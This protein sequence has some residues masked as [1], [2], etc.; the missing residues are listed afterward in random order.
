MILFD[1]QCAIPVFEGLLDHPHDGILQTLLFELA[2]WHA[3]AKLR[4]HTEST[5]K[6]L[7]HSTTRL[8][9][10]IREFESRTCSTFP[11]KDLPSDDAARSRQRRN[12]STAETSTQKIRKLNLSTYKLHALGHYVDAI[13]QFGPAD[14]YSTQTVSRLRTQT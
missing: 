13:R 3:L 7:E 2:T 14:G 6:A 9:K 11:T 1:G 12:T 5:V 4:L 10:A 8:G